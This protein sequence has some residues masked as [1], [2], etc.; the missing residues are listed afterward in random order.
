MSFGAVAEAYERGRPSYPSDAVAWLI[1]D[2]PC[3]VLE[4]GAGTGKLTRQLLAHG[5]QVV[6]TDPDPAMLDV[7][8]RELPEVHTI[9]GSAEDIDLPDQSV[10]VVVAAQSYHWFD[11]DRALPEVARLLRPGGRFAIAWN[12]RDNRIPWVKRLGT[13]IAPS[14][15]T[16]EDQTGSDQTSVSEPHDPTEDLA[17][18][19]LFIGVEESL[20]K[21]RQ[22]L[23][24]NTIADLVLSC[25]QIS[26]LDDDARG[27]ILQ[28]VLA[29]YDDY[30]RGM[31][32]M[33]LP[34]FTCCYRAEVVEI[35]I[36]TPHELDQL[37]DTIPRELR[38]RVRPAR[39]TDPAGQP[40]ITDSQMILIDF[41]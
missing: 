8:T 36:A 21:S 12:E 2:K 19:E 7:L 38:G 15:Q 6:A 9:L 16:S 32:G 14:Q 10:D 17:W 29:L 27:Q 3:R 39:A 24:R 34:Y 20:F 4:L 13:L 11:P 5:H 30:G 26:T 22:H 25:S 35:E 23:D 33:Q 31:D 40:D 41:R 1:G 18:S 28:A 37:T